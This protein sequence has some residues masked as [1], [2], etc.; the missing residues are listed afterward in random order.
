VIYHLQEGIYG[1][2]RKRAENV[3]EN[4]LQIPF[5]TT[6]MEGGPQPGKIGPKRGGK[7]G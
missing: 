6:P 5:Y 1:N 4:K 3:Q 2:T 7:Q